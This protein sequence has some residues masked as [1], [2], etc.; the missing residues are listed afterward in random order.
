VTGS[1]RNDPFPARIEEDVSGND[2]RAGATLRKRRERAIQVAV[3]ASLDRN[4]LLT[5]RMRR[6]LQRA[7]LRARIGAAQIDEQA[8]QPSLWYQVTQQSQAF[9]LEPD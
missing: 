6:L 7:R 1:Q 2:E 8:D 5:N 3:A 9:T 4:D